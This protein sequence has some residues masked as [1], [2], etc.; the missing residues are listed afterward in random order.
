MSRLFNLFN[1][2]TAAAISVANT[3]LN[4]AS[5]VVSSVTRIVTNVAN[6]VLSTAI[7]PFIPAVEYDDPD[8]L[9]IDGELVENLNALPGLRAIGHGK[10]FHYTGTFPANQLLGNIDTVIPN[11]FGIQPY[12]IG[13]RVRST[14]I[15]NAPFVWNIIR[16][17]G[18]L[19]DFFNALGVAATY[20][21]AGKQTLEEL[22]SAS[23]SSAW[24]I[25]KSVSPF[26]RTTDC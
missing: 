12:P 10:N 20:A 17:R 19:M 16:N 13:I 2:G 22:A 7:Q 4:T 15:P 18:D 3:V 5:Q 26:G 9:I 23:D 14:L 8:T 24:G 11:R 1:R 25:L 6:R 21:A